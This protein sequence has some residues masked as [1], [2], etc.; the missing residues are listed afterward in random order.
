ME[1]SG[2]SLKKLTLIMAVCFIAL[3][4]LFLLSIIYQNSAFDIIEEF[5]AE[6]VGLG[7]KARNFTR[8]SVIVDSE[9]N[10]D[11][12]LGGI[13]AP[14]FDSESCISRYQSS[15]YRKPSPH[16]PSNYLLSKLRKYEN[17]HKHCGPDAK[18]YKKAVKDLNTSSH[19]NITKGCK[20]VVW[21]PSNGLGN[22][23]VS[24]TSA[25][26]YALLTNRV[27]LVHHGTDMDDL[28]CE[29]FPN[30]SWLLPKDFPLKDKFDSSEWRNILS[31][32]N[33]LNNSNTNTSSLP[34]PAFLLLYLAYDY[35]YHDK[36]FYLDQNQDFLQKVPWLIMRSDQY[37]VPYLFLIQSFR[38]EL[39]RLFP[40][41]ETVFHHL[42]RYLFHPSNQAWGLITRF[43]Q[44]YLARADEIIGLQIRLFDPKA[45]SSHLVM[46]QILSCTE[47]ESL[48]PQPDKQKHVASLSKNQTLKAILVASLHS[49]YYENLKNMYWMKPTANGEAIGVFQ[50]SSEEYQHFGDN[51]HNI[52]AWAEMNILS[53][54]DVL[55]TSSWSTFGYVAQGLGGLKP[56]ILFMPDNQ[57]SP[58]P[59]CQRVMSMEPCFH[60]PPGYD[61][62][63]NSIPDNV[64]LGV[65]VKHCEDV[66]WGV[67][68]VNK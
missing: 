57:T 37:F 5:T 17:R 27:L 33:L 54:S 13:L 50:P 15:L 46:K 68:L 12:L 63:Q 67:K 59:P 45:S 9:D 62:K 11:K 6:A 56:W 48:L 16:K 38:K 44:A 34:P 32:G 22:R 35:D 66:S 61:R 24:M 2:F 52:K 18:S 43:Y 3:P 8:F 28:F 53:L 36:L 14:G 19:T 1:R 20:Y 49:V 58:D 26:L 47:K 41:K 31:Y 39:S 55:I 51:M 21:L 25:F 29:P 65:D 30:T 40:D 4:L 64:D 60:F 42:G 10:S 7:G 23:I